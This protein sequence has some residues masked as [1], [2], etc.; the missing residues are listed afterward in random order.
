MKSFLLDPQDSV[1][2]R[3]SV[4]TAEPVPSPAEPQLS[5]GAEPQLLP[6]RG[7]GRPCKY[8]LL[9]AVINTAVIDTMKDIGAFIGNTVDIAN[10][11]IYL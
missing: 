8:L 7:R 6:K 11:T 3:E 5:P 1:E 4:E 9:M 10:I 2:P